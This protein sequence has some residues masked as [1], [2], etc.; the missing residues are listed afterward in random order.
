MQVKQVA[1]LAAVL[2]WEVAQAVSLLAPGD[3]KSVR[4][5]AET[6]A[7]LWEK[8]SGETPAIIDALPEKGDVVV[9]GEEQS[10]A[11]VFRRRLDGKLPPN[12]L[13]DGSDAYRLL[14]QKD[15]DRTLLFLLNARPRSLFYAV[16]R[17][18]ELRAD[19]SW[20]WDGDRIPKGRAP[21][22]DGIDVTESPRFDWRGLRYFGHRS[23]HRF[24][25][26][27]WT[28]DDWKREVD[29]MLK[30]RLNFFMLRIGQD[31]LFQ[32]AF[33]DIVSYDDA[34]WDPVGGKPDHWYNDRSLM[35][36]LKT[37]AAMRKALMDYA[38]DRDLV[39]CA[40]TGTMTHWYS[41]T[42]KAFM[43][44]VKPEFIRGNTDKNPLSSKSHP[45][46]LVWD[47]EKDKWLDAYWKLTQ[48]DVDNYSGA[49]MFHTIGLAE[50]G[51]FNGDLAKSCRLK[52]ATYR[53]ILSKLREHYPNAP[54]LVGSWDFRADWV[55]T[56]ERV[57]AFVGTLDPKNTILLDYISDLPE[58]N[59]NLF[60]QWGV[61]GKFPWMFGIFHAYE[62]QSDMR[63]NYPQL[64]DRLPIAAADPM[65]KGLFMW[66]ENSHQ[67][68][69]MLDYFPAMGWDPSQYRL[70]S[71]LPDFCRRR[72]GAE[73]APAMLALWLRMVP[74]LPTDSWHICYDPTVL[75]GDYPAA[76]ANVRAGHYC[77]LNDRR[78]RYYRDR[79]KTLAPLREEMSAL[80]ADLAALDWANADE[81]TR[82]D[83]IDMARAILGRQLEG[84]V[85]RIGLALERRCN[86]QPE[87]RAAHKDVANEAV[88]RPLADLRRR[89][90]LLAD[91]LAAS[92]EFSLFDSLQRIRAAG[93]SN[94]NFEAT[95]KRNS[96]N[97]YCRSQIY[98]LVRNVYE[99]QFAILSGFLEKAMSAEDGFAGWEK[100][101]EELDALFAVP[102]TA[103]DARPLEEM[104][105]DCPAAF[106][107]LPEVL[108]QAATL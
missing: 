87:T 70:E 18:F 43:E 92:P 80:L 40:D 61:V 65:C 16:Y 86:L 53:R 55:W 22:I 19:C 57:R 105:P 75:Y 72:Y 99:K 14:S 68:T 1:L 33:P 56:P 37:R 108:R 104:R 23:L 48:A 85:A 10:N 76:Y 46:C 96:N 11:F 93:P 52:V 81:W 78:L 20:F 60:T 6:F 9:F 49:D 30:R 36:P 39:H 63:G 83:G 101:V 8:V 35:W 12:E 21:D 69:L 17:F 42:P 31:D 32:K 103:F 58:G 29:W 44:K 66:A 34:D 88:R 73:K 84:D 50:R 51:Y 100:R 102:A 4:L 89:L 106:A 62:A 79:E 107:R 98:E 97:P 3:S 90:G 95:L 77:A 7:D 94:P 5:A 41:R 47:I 82:R 38:H 27:H 15:G 24:Q 28:L 67:D 45:S 54:L 64:C 13:R 25:A 91:L 26:E 74:I 2:C 59:R 71:F